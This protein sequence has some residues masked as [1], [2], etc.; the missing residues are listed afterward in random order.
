MKHN[1][2]VLYVKVTKA[3]YTNHTKSTDQVTDVV[4]SP[5]QQYMS[6]I[7]YNFVVIK[8]KIYSP[9]PLP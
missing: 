4:T 2:T 1:K 5:A 7:Q 9:L 8:P 6:V 3:K